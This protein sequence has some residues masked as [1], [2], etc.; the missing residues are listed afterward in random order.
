M[1]SVEWGPH[2]HPSAAGA[3]QEF[4]TAVQDKFATAVLMAVSDNSVTIVES[5]RQNLIFNA[6]QDVIVRRRFGTGRNPTARA[7]RGGVYVDFSIWM[8]SRAAAR[9]LLQSDKLSKASI[10]DELLRIGLRTIQA[11]AVE[12]HVDDAL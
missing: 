9:E 3:A 10:D 11:V 5:M 12:P 7:K 1:L 4:H 6:V 2:S 8:R